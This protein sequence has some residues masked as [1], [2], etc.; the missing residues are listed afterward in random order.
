[1]TMKKD[2]VKKEDKPTIEIVK[3]HRQV[4]IVKPDMQILLSSE[5]ISE[6]MNY[7]IDKARNILDNYNG[8]K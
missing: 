6:D 8:N 5:C 1:M 7:L 3:L 2:E 4:Q